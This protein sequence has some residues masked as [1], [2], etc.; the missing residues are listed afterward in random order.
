MRET[1]PPNHLDDKV[2]PDQWVANKEVSLS[3]GQEDATVVARKDP[4]PHTT[5]RFRVV[6]WGLATTLNRGVEQGLND[7]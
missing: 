2:D 5:P 1:G 6:A 7:F 3:V 4:T